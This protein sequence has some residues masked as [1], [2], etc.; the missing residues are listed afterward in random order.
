MTKFTESVV[1]DA[2]LGWLQALGY[3]I[4]Q[5]PDIAAGE[6]GAE[7]SDPNYRDVLLGRRL[8]QALVSLTLISRASKCFPKS[9]QAHET[10]PA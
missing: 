10:Q 7:R 6:P 5:G 3:E 2:T 8:D 9:G 4:R 1:K